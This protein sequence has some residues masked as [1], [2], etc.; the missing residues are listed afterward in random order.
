MTD[1]HVPE[2]P[3]TVAVAATIA[4]IISESYGVEAGSR[5]YAQMSVGDTAAKYLS[6]LYDAALAL[7][8]AVAA[9][10]PDPLAEA[11]SAS[12]GSDAGR[13]H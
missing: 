4:C 10:Q 3:S 1:T 2:K 12:N 6:A 5:V 7:E 9:T 13:V 11:T 8:R